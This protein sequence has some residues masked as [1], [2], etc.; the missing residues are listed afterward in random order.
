MSHQSAHPAFILIAIL[1]QNHMW[2]V[3]MF[4]RDKAKLLCADMPCLYTGLV[5]MIQFHSGDLHRQ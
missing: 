4:L 3:K 2:L 5:T 1:L